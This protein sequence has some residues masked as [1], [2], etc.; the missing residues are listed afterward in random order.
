VLVNPFRKPDFHCRSNRQRKRSGDSVCSA[1][2]TGSPQGTLYLRSVSL[3][4][5][6]DGA[7][8]PRCPVNLRSLSLRSLVEGVQFTTDI[9]G[10]KQATCNGLQMTQQMTSVSFVSWKKWILCTLKMK[11]YLRTQFSITGRLSHVLRYFGKYPAMG[12][13]RY[14]WGAWR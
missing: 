8:S 4:S 11:T 10:D 9:Q 2:A 12:S 14:L 1:D 7:V 13:A 5:L 3:M 6:F